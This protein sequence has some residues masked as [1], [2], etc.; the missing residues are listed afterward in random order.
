ML[1]KLIQKHRPRTGWVIVAEVLMHSAAEIQHL[2][3]QHDMPATAT[4]AGAAEQHAKNRIRA[5]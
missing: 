1:H 3:E 2:T 5:A 4:A